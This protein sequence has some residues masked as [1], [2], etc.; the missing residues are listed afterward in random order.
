ME[1][2]LSYA[3]PNSLSPTFFAAK[4][5][6][7]GSSAVNFHGYNCLPRK[8]KFSAREL[9]KFVAIRASDSAT[10]AA[11][12]ASAATWL[13][14]PVGDGDFGHIGYKIARPGAF[15]IDSN[16]VTVGRVP[17]KAD[18]VIPVPTVSGLHARIQKTEE[19][20]LITDLDST[21]G[22]FIN[23]K[24]LLPGVVSPASAG[25]LITFGDTNLAIFKIYR[26]EKEEL[27]SEGEAEKVA[28]TNLKSTTSS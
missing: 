20:L 17:E 6:S 11:T 9:R 8:L 21:N 1:M 13:L 5:T 23:E 16:V 3:N 7:F 15:E 26:V 2:S 19:K 25:N 27:S 22:T 4:T 12:N 14:E 24:R 28:N 18:I 10:T